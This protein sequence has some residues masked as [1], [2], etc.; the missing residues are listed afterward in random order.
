MIR[1]NREELI[2]NLYNHL[3]EYRDYEEMVL[4]KDPSFNGLVTKDNLS[5]AIV[6][7]GNIAT[8]ALIKNG[9]EVSNTLIAGSYRVKDT[10]RENQFESYYQGKTLNSHVVAMISGAH[11]D[12]DETEE[13]KF[14]SNDKICVLP[15][16][17]DSEAFLIEPTLS[18]RS[19]RVHDSE[20]LLFEVMNNI[21][22]N[23][24]N[25]FDTIILMTERIPCK[26][27]TNI[28]IDFAKNHSTQ[29][30]IFYWLDT[31]RENEVREIE[32]IATH[33]KKHKKAAKLISLMEIISKHA[34]NITYI[35]RTTK[36]EKKII[37]A[38]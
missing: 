9:I 12:E 13:V 16:P 26:S 17:P 23:D 25:S 31:G 15:P 14:T 19:T 29:I 28:I 1:I 5:K 10:L 20:R 27:C 6:K 34:G 18:C 35:D 3:L 4:E 7:K 32:K 36:I 33:I 21:K 2:L 11:V 37:K 38:P 8:C 22:I 30:I 24:K